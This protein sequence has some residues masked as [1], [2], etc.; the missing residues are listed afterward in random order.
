MAELERM[1]LFLGEQVSKGGAGSGHFGHAGRPGLVGGSTP[2]STAQPAQPYQA[3][4]SEQPTL[5][6][7][8][9]A[10]ERAIAAILDWTK[11]YDAYHV[12]GPFFARAFENTQVIFELG[13]DAAGGIRLSYIKTPNEARHQGYA[14]RALKELCDI[15]DKHQLHISGTVRPERGGLNKKQLFAWY[16]KFGFERQPYTMQPDKL[17][18]DIIRQ[19]QPTQ[20]G[21]PGSGNPNQPRDER[22]WWVD[23]GGS[24]PSSTPA[25]K[26]DAHEVRSITANTYAALSDYLQNSYFEINRWMRS[27]RVRPRNALE[28][29]ASL[30]A[31]MI[32]EGFD[33]EGVYNT[34]NKTQWVFRGISSDTV[35]RQFAKLRKGSV[36]ADK[37]FVSTSRDIDIAYNA[38]NQWAEKQVMLNIRLPKGT[39]YL[40]GRRDEKE[41]VLDRNLPMK[42]LSINKLSPNSIDA[43]V[44]VL[45]TRHKAAMVYVTF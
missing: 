18:D 29:S 44:E 17:S 31:D 1:R 43:D 11:S 32:A 39:K 16:G 45:P 6:V 26:P 25:N 27:G 38:A 23:G 35:F 2:S 5:R 37:A 3:N 34:V 20:K 8:T 12:G 36:I 24:A 14:S 30:S 4:S 13:P 33:T 40:I 22:G 19:P 10:R 21:G 42:V 15:A 28:E 9:P 41:W 7:T